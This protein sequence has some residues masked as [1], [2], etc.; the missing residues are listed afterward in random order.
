MG[1][2]KRAPQQGIDANAAMN[3]TSDLSSLAGGFAPGAAGDMISAVGNLSDFGSLAT[4]EEAPSV[5]DTASAVNGFAGLAG[6][7]LS[8]DA[9]S[10]VT[11][12][13][14]GGL[15]VVDGVTTAF[16]GEAE[17]DSRILGG[18]KATSAGMGRVRSR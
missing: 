2:K 1:G 14:G 9:L 10:S 5:L 16:D 8:N 3:A 12:T 11:G 7:A 18:A 6:P 17:L 15:D 13:L 4:S